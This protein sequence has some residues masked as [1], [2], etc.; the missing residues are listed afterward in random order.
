M[1]KGNIVAWTLGYGDRTIEEFLD[2][3]KSFNIEAV[4]DMRLFPDI[5]KHEH[6]LKD[7][8]RETLKS[9][10]IE[11]HLAGHQLGAPRPENQNSSNIALQKKMRGFADYMATPSFKGAV[12]YLVDLCRNQ[13]VVLVNSEKDFKK[14]HRKLLADYLFL[15]E[16]VSLVHILDRAK[17]QEHSV[18]FSARYQF[19]TVVYDNIHEPNLIIN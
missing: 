18:T 7:N 3:L 16:S 2:L 9:N 13:R 11:Y 17:V 19:D 1:S 15:V 10:G 12:N 14:C 5:G 6:F 8:L 4:V